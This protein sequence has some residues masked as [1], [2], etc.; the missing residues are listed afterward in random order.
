MGQS[1][2]I[3]GNEGFGHCGREMIKSDKSRMNTFTLTKL[4]TSVFSICLIYA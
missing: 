1:G 2:D 4:A 3:P